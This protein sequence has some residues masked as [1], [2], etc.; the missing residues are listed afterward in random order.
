[1]PHVP[2]L[3]GSTVSVIIPVHNREQLIGSA[4][5]S[6]LRQSHGNFELIIVD[7][8][9]TD[10]SV[11]VVARF[12]DPR[13]RIVRHAQNRGIPAARNTGLEAARGRFVAW[14]DSDDIARPR[15][16]ERQL[17]FL[18][19]HPSVAMVGCA[20]GKIGPDGQRKSGVRVP[21]TEPDTIAAWLLFRSAFQQSSVMGRADVLKACPYRLEYDVCED[22]DV[23]LR[24]A[25]DHVLANLPEAL[26][27][28]RIHPDQTVRRRQALI[29]DRKAQ[30]YAEPLAR[31]GMEPGPEDLR[32]HTL[33]GKTSLHG[34]E[35]PSDFLTWTDRWLQR[36][37]ACNREAGW[38]DPGSLALATAW[39][40]LLACRAASGRTGRAAAIRAWAGSPLAAGLGGPHARRWARRA[41]PLLL[42]LR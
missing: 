34:A 40:W 3:H 13:I 22:L 11:G 27:D 4:V 5:A 37:R 29:R 9:S 39:F 26:V 6:V 25:R 23:F 30:L 28:R 10:R 32:R 33:L 38:L 36:M 21:P 20:A 41:M 35:I 17:A 24:L 14:L 1:M 12:A 19:A 2:R 16:L 8:G 7:D 15:R 42:R 18:D 31:L